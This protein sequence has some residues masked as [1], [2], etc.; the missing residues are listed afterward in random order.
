MARPRIRRTT[1]TRI[2][3]RDLCTCRE[4]GRREWP[5]WSKWH[6]GHLRPY[7]KG[8]RNWRNLALICRDCNLHISAKDWEPRIKLHW[9]Q[10]VLDWSLVI[11]LQDWP[12][13]EDL[14]GDD[15][16]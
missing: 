14:I 1:R 2:T 16:D 3:I 6:M 7:S 5:W 8:G 9:W 15:N 11:I 12:R 13:F 10:H 4:C